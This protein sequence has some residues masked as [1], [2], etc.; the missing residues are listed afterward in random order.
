[1]VPLQKNI[2]TDTENGRPD[3]VVSKLWEREYT[4]MSPDFKIPISPEHLLTN[5]PRITAK[6]S[7]NKIAKIYG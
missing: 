7:S 3:I 5:Q 6:G 4:F 2:S 1:M